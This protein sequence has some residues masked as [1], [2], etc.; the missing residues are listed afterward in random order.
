MSLFFRTFT[1]RVSLAQVPLVPSLSLQLSNSVHRHPLSSS[2]LKNPP[3][4]SCFCAVVI[5][6]A[7]F[8]LLGKISPS[9]TDSFYDIDLSI[10]KF[11]N[12]AGRGCFNCGGCKC[13][14]FALFVRETRLPSSSSRCSPTLYNTVGH[15]A[16]NCPKA[17]TPTW[18]VQMCLCLTVVLIQSFTFTAIIVSE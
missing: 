16:A 7:R 9:S 12:M 3:C 10:Q 14:Y 8:Y 5:P 4:K 18:Y 6:T 11:N 1:S 13:F 17:G 2:S 15:Q